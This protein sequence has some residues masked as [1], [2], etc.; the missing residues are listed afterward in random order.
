MSAQQ[1]W[2]LN[3][4]LLLIL[5]L[6]FIS[7][8][9]QSPYE[10]S[11]WHIYSYIWY[12]VTTLCASIALA[13]VMY[14]SGR[15]TLSIM[16]PWV[17]MAVVVF[18]PTAFLRWS[19]AWDISI[20]LDEYVQVANSLTPFQESAIQQQPPFYYLI[21]T[22]VV[23][24]MGATE[25][26]LRSVSLFFGSACVLVG[27]LLG[28]IMKMRGEIFLL[29]L[30]SLGLT[31]ILIRYSFEGR[32]NITGVFVCLLWIC[33]LMS[34]IMSKS[35]QRNDWIRI[36][37]GT[38]IFCLTIGLQS[39][40]LPLYSIL[41]LIVI[42]FIVEQRQGVLLKVAMAQ[43]AALLT[44]LPLLYGIVM[45]SI[46]RNQ[47]QSVNS[48]GLRFIGLLDFRWWTHAIRVFD[49]IPFYGTLLLVGAGALMLLILQNKD[50]RIRISYALSFVGVIFL[51]FI[52]TAVFQ[53]T[54]NWDF[55]ERYFLCYVVVFLLTVL[56]LCNH[57]KK[58]CSLCKVRLSTQVLIAVFMAMGGAL[59]IKKKLHVSDLYNYGS[60]F[61]SVYRYINDHSG[62]SNLIAMFTVLSEES[63]EPKTLVAPEFYLQPKQGASFFYRGYR[64]GVVREG[65]QIHEIVRSL[66]AEDISDLFLIMGPFT[67]IEDQFFP[68]LEGPLGNH[69]IKVMGSE[70]LHF[71]RKGEPV[72]KDVEKYFKAWLSSSPQSSYIFKIKEMLFYIS[73]Y[74]EDFLKSKYIYNDLERSWPENRRS[75]LH[76]SKLKIMREL[77]SKKVVQ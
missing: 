11:G 58:L 46:I 6:M 33:T 43:V 24:Y 31:P 53:I 12:I 51:P 34:P 66:F 32:P 4:S 69:L 2:T 25:A 21:S 48:W 39:L 40:A 42:G 76:V 74:S 3:V 68:S 30:L 61:R 67:L 18:L 27:A 8:F 50:N 47:F 73:Y 71:S 44:F 26:W 64:G 41:M 77:L 5:T 28:R 57:E 35:F 23:D 45:E 59:Y 62:A 52:F 63:W 37:I 20:W 36:F 70:I 14:K 38:Y 49:M 16:N 9:Y 29:W 10:L 13:W 15:P 1:E 65:D 75:R 54:I 7:G 72:F 22:A 60:D 17:L 55:F 19:Y 56:T